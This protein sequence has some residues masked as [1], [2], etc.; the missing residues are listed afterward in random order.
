MT[1]ESQN[2]RRE[3]DKN[4]Q[5]H[6]NSAQNKD[7]KHHKN[8]REKRRKKREGVFDPLNESKIDRA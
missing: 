1:N 3:V 7:F 4:S 2:G 5:N 8:L 6:D